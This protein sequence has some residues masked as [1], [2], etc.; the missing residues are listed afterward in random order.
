MGR[1]APR[2]CHWPSQS[3]YTC[4]F[5]VGGGKGDL[6]HAIFQLSAGIAAWQLLL[7]LAGEAAW[8]AVELHGA[9]DGDQGGK[10][11]AWTLTLIGFVELHRH[12]GQSGLK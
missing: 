1:Q 6:G 12:S 7:Q 5:L 10:L 3:R 8:H 4:P 2:Q 9:G 11:L